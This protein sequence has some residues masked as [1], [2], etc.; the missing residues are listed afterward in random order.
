[1]GWGTSRT[2]GI[3]ARAAPTADSGARGQEGGRRVRLA[4]ATSGGEG[5]EERV[6]AAVGRDW[7]HASARASRPRRRIGLA[8]TTSCHARAGVALRRPRCGGGPANG[9]ASGHKWWRG[10]S[11]GQNRRDTAQMQIHLT[12]RGQEENANPNASTVLD[13]FS[14]TLE[15]ATICASSVRGW[16]N[17]KKTHGT[18]HRILPICCRSNVLGQLQS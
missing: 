8:A 18:V 14:S 1:M 9:S 2:G 10:R 15:R 16:V 6:G 5:D 12:G 17:R 3:G 13:V 11:C 4:D 7:R